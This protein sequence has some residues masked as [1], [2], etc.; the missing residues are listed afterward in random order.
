M[1]KL[2]RQKE[3]SG[4]RGDLGKSLQIGSV[5]EPGANTVPFRYFYSLVFSL[6]RGK[7]WL[8]VVKGFG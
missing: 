5:S 7:S 1:P 2:S 8:K 4:H 3:A 6:L